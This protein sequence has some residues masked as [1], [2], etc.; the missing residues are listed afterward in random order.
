MQSL[1]LWKVFFFLNSPLFTEWLTI[2]FI[3]SYIFSILLLIVEHYIIKMDIIRHYLLPNSAA[4]KLCNQKYEYAKSK[5]NDTPYINV[6]F[7]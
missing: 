4:L 1:H 2:V 5:N 3:K 6:I 7:L